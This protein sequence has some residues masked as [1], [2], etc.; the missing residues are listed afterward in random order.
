MPPFG[1]LPSVVLGSHSTEHIAKPVFDI[2]NAVACPCRFV[3]NCTP[4]EVERPAPSN[5]RHHAAPVAGGKR[6][7]PK[8]RGGC[9]GAEA[10]TADAQIGGGC[11]GGY[12]VRRLEVAGGGV[13]CV[14]HLSG[15]IALVNGTKVR[16]ALTRVKCLRNYSRELREYTYILSS[17]VASTLSSPPG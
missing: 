4:Q 6:I 14:G 16:Q 13:G 5:G 8:L 12:G 3:G 1:G 2:P 9:G 17:N 11:G 10:L 15:A 7:G